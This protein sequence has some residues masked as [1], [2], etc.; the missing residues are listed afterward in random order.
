MRFNPP[1]CRIALQ[2]PRC[3]SVGHR[4]C[5]DM[6]HLPDG[7][8]PK[9]RAIVMS[10]LCLCTEFIIL[11]INC[12]T[13]LESKPVK[14]NM[15]DTKIYIWKHIQLG[16]YFFLHITNSKVKTYRT[17][18]VTAHAFLCEEVQCDI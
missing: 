2:A 18:K 6:N 12:F 3:P 7:R 13:L 11:L 5:N 1:E 4:L 16:S 10:L 9:K 17:K 14:H 8:G 15:N